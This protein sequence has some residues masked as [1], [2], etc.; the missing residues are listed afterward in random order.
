[1]TLPQVIENQVDIPV[2]LQEHYHEKDGKWL[3]Q[4]DPQFEDVTALKGVLN[5][6]RTLR[7]DV[8]K[9]FSDLKMRF[10]GV[11]PDEYHKLQERVKGLDDADVYD[12]QGIEALILRRTE[13]MKAEHQRLLETKERELA[14]WRQK[15]E[16]SDR[17]WRQDRIK[18]AL[19]SAVSGSGVDKDAVEDGV[20]RGLAVFTDLDDEGNVIAR[21]GQD[22]VY[23]K[24]GINALSPTEWITQLKA[25]GTARH[26]WP[27]SSGGGA[28]AHH[29]GP[30]ANIDWNALPPAERLT[31]WRELQ[32]AHNR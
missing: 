18:T 12:R 5:Q 20:T 32:A 14:Q 22:I 17:R 19:L 23:G 26:L 9:T 3:L 27:P 2:G 10:E 1:M 28:P 8:E 6:E 29:G 16:E 31:R 4:T 15:T 11:D 13:S 24:D 30:G 25:S 7:R 21:K